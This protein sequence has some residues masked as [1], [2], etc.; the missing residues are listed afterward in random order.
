MKKFSKLFILCTILVSFTYISCD[1]FHGDMGSGDPPKTTFNI[2]I[3]NIVNYLN[4]DV[5]NTP[6]GASEPG[7]ITE[8]SGFYT[9]DF[10]AVSGARLSFATMSVVSNDWF[11]A[12]MGAGIDL[13]DNGAPVT[14]DITE[15]IH[16]WDAGVEEENM[17][18]RTSEPGGAEAGDPDDD[19]TVR[20]VEEDVSSYIAVELSYAESTGTFTLIIKNI[21]G[22][23]AD[24]NPIIITPGILVLHAQDNPLFEQGKPDRGLGLDKIAIQGNPMNIYHWVT[25]MGS[26]GAPL[27][28]SSSYTVLS[29]GLVYA[30]DDN[31]DPVF[32]ESESAV[33]GNGLENIAEDG[34]TAI[35]YEYIGNDLKLPVAKSNETMP[36]GPG[37]SL[38]FTLEVPK[39]YKLGYSTMF[40]FSNDWFL[41]HQNEGFPLFQH[42]GNPYSGKIATEKTYLFDAGTEMDQPI[43][44][45]PD[46]APFQTAPNMG[47][48][49]E[50]NLIRRV[51]EINDIQFGKGPINS[52]DGVS[53]SMDH[54]GG[55]NLVE[56]TITPN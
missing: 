54:R 49:D 15:Q 6:A 12:P 31:I 33:P 10:K 42:N 24:T 27:R 37:A 26:T 47:V 14:G 34:N 3:S 19:N 51:M 50:N 18:T 17:A 45:G 22:A 7:P 13:F 20:L 11:F 30:F 44:F 53:G 41:A 5:F 1:K 16:L 55:Y 36:I 38:T 8:A 52:S 9:I 43:G 46:Q 21:R 29:P 32:M 25:E 23:G 40:V 35:M 2:T 56:V 39:G 28:L 48:S 4:A